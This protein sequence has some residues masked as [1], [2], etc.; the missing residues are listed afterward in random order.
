MRYR[1]FVTIFLAI[2][3]GLFLTVIQSPKGN[4]VNQTLP[5][6]E[7][8]KPEVLL[9]GLK[10]QSHLIAQ[11]IRLT[12]RWKSDNGGIYYMRQVDNELFWLG[13]GGDRTTWANVYHG[14]ISGNSIT[15]SWAD[16]P[17]ANNRLAGELDINIESP[18]RL[19]A[20]RKTG[21]FGGGVWTR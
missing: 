15:G 8:S 12:G 6:V 21:G 14:Y 4:A 2:L 17:K 20:T 7:V 19:V 9:H 3:A 10:P 1:Q 13:E 18:R 16:V 11:S 5:S